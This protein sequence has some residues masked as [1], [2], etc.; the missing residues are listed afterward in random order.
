[1]EVV[2]QQI[3]KIQGVVGSFVCDDDGKLLGQA[4]PPMYDFEL[5]QDAAGIIADSFVGV[6]NA[7]G[8]VSALDL[9]YNE[10]RI[11][12]RPVQNC[13]L[14]LLCEQKINVQLL[15]MS[16]SVAQKKLEKAIQAAKEK[17]VAPAVQSS[18]QSNTVTAAA[19]P[20]REIRRDGKGAILIAESTKNAPLIQW[21]LA[22]EEVAISRDLMKKLFTCLNTGSIK[23][24][25]L[26]NR[27]SNK[28]KTFYVIVFD[29]Q[30]GQLF[31]DKIVLPTAALDAVGLKPGDDVTVE[32]ASSGV[33][34][35]NVVLAGWD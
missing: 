6:S 8:G 7:S 16:L 18:V 9:R 31:D 19:A 35:N 30:P 32:V 20:P 12:V 29:T 28:N 26:I 1:M 21:D 34:D 10:G 22:K 14:L 33:F 24:L 13:Y 17:P 2:L 5:L 27:I 11:I 4:L 3:N 15:N 25:K 23:K